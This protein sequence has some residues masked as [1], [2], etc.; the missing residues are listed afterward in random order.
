M[1]YF[2]QITTLLLGLVAFVS[3]F[4]N[5]HERR[6]VWTPR[7]LERKDESGSK[8]NNNKD[9]ITIVDTTAIELTEKSR[10]SEVELT[11]LVQEKIRIEDQKRTAKDNVRKNHYRNKNRNV[12]CQSLFHLSSNNKKY[13]I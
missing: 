13:V 9:A 10:N 6:M 11:I 1:M 7:S 12:V 8:N 5:P 2:T 3:A 4:P